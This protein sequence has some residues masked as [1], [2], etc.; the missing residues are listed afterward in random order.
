M[1]YL[2]ENGHH[3]GKSLCNVAIPWGFMIKAAVLRE[4]DIYDHIFSAS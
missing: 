4:G 1:I 2:S 3:R